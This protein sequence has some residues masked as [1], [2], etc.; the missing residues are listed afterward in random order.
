MLSTGAKQMPKSVSE[1]ARQLGRIGGS[2]TSKAKTAANRAKIVAY[3]DAVRKGE[4]VPPKHRKGPRKA[5]KSPRTA[6]KG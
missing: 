1:A 4:K 2:K 5:V 3:W 6:R